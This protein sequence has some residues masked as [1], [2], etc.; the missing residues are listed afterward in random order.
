VWVLFL[1]E[2]L[3]F[4]FSITCKFCLDWTSWDDF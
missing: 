3:L 2:L 4:F 1:F